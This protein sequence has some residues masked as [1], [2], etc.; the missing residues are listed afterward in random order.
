MLTDRLWRLYSRHIFSDWHW[1]VEPVFITPSG[2]K[3]KVYVLSECFEEWI[4]HMLYRRGT[5][6]R[7][8]IRHQA[9]FKEW[10]VH[11]TSVA[12]KN[13]ACTFY[14]SS[15][16]NC[17]LPVTRANL[18]SRSLVL[19][20][21][22]VLEWA[23]TRYRSDSDEFFFCDKLLTVRRRRYLDRARNVVD[24]CFPEA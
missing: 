22:G 4:V 17:R 21:S 3:G 2:T 19:Y 24:L 20:E 9:G 6:N 12:L 16:E 10:S 7:V 1:R 18:K 11:F 14:W 15:C 5:E 23:H 8:N 13:G